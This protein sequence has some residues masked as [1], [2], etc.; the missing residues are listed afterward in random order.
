MRGSHRWLA[1]LGA[2]LFGALTLLGCGEDAKQSGTVL[3]TTPDM[4]KEA[5]ASDKF[6]QDQSK[7]K[8]KKSGGVRSLDPPDVLQAK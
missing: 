5:E 1:F 6:M 7:T 2:G 4:L 3:E 8:T